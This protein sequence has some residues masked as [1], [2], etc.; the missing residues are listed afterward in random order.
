MPPRTLGEFEV[1]RKKLS[2]YI[3]AAKNNTDKKTAIALKSEFDKLYDDTLDNLLFA[4]K[5]GDEVLKQN[6]KNFKLLLKNREFVN[7]SRNH[8]DLKI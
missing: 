7:N 1:M 8:I 3:N 4:G 2:N 5:E 6:I